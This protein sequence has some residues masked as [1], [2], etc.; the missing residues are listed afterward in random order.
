MLATIQKLEEELKNYNERVTFLNDFIHYL[1][2]NEYENEELRFSALDKAY[3]LQNELDFKKSLISQRES[4]IKQINE[5]EELKKKAVKEMPE[6]LEKSKEVHDEML[7]DL[8]KL[9]S[10]KKTKEIKEAIKMV[11][12]QVDE[13]SEIIDGIQERYK[14]KNFQQIL[15]DFRQINN[16]IKI[17]N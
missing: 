15:N 17:K 12:M 10:S 16:I 2:V 3:R 1:R 8:Y 5:Q 11:E 7:D 13:V 14:A 9:K 6:L 4:Q